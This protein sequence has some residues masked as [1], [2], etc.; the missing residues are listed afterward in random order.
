MMNKTSP[1]PAF[2][3]HKIEGERQIEEIIFITILVSVPKEMYGVLRGNVLWSPKPG[4]RMG[5]GISREWYL[6]WHQ[7]DR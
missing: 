6:T 1:A 7:E 5:R 4:R 3:E 2:M